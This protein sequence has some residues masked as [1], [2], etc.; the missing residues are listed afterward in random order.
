MMFDEDDRPKPKDALLPR[1]LEGLSRE[2]LHDYLDWLASEKERTEAALKAKGSF[3][4]AA[5]S[6]FK[7]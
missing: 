6:L 7:S 2:D 4:A 5:A 1:K 3:E